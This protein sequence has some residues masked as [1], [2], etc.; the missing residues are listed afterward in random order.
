M[1]R[2]IPHCVWNNCGIPNTK[3]AKT[4]YPRASSLNNLSLNSPELQPARGPSFLP[5]LA[6]WAWNSIQMDLTPLLTAV[7]SSLITIFLCLD[8][9]WQG[10]GSWVQ[11][12]RGIMR[13]T[14]SSV[15]VLSQQQL[16]CGMG[17][18]THAYINTHISKMP[19][20]ICLSKVAG[21]GLS[22]QYTPSLTKWFC[23][24]HSV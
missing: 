18:R 24:G 19:R 10:W 5:L 1:D 21:Q 4:A 16:T 12:D 17:T 6:C 3:Q 22:T 23:K 9:K 7:H 2:Q 13:K 15:P 20:W 8:G 11:K 14:T